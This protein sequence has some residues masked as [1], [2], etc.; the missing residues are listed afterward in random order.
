MHSLSNK[1]TQ[2]ILIGLFLQSM[3]VLMVE[4]C[5]ARIL[6]IVLWHHFAFLIISC[7]LLGYGASGSWLLIFKRPSHP[8]YPSVLFAITIVPLFMLVNR[9]PFEPMLLPVQWFQ[10][11]WLVMLFLL[12]SL[13]FFLGGLSLNILFQTYP[14]NVFKLYAV[15]LTGAALGSVTAIAMMPYWIELEWLAVIACIGG[16]ST[17]FLAPSIQKR[18]ISRTIVIVMLLV[19]WFQA[20]PEIKISPYKNLNLALQQKDSYLINRQWDAASRVDW[21]QSHI[22]RFAPGL[23]LNFRDQLPNQIGLTIDGSLMTAFTS[24]QK[25]DPFYDF[26]P[27]SILHQMAPSPNKIAVI[28]A[29][30]GQVINQA[31]NSSST[32]IDIQTENKIIGKWLNKQYRQSRISLYAEPIRTFL[33][34]S[35]QSYDVIWA[36]L[37][38]ALPVGYSG[39]DVLNEVNLETVEGLKTA[40]SHLNQS[41]WFFFHRYIYLPPRSELRLVASLNEAM[42]ELGWQPAQHLAVFRT[43]S[44][45]VILISKQKWQDEYSKRIQ[46]YCDKRGYTLVYYPGMPMASANLSN[47]LPTPIYA[48][49]VRSLLATPD[50]FLENSIFKLDPVYDDQPFFYYFLKWNHLP[51]IWQLFGYK[52]EALVENGILVPVA[53]VLVG[54]V[55]LL[56]IGFPFFFNKRFSHTFSFSMFYFFFIGLGYM[57]IEIVLFEK[58]MLFLG[59]PVHSLAVILGGLLISSGIGSF[60]GG[61]LIE[62]QDKWFQMALLGLILLYTFGFSPVLYSLIHFNFPVRLFFSL[63]SVAL[64]GILMGIPFPSGIKRI[65]RKQKNKPANSRDKIA[66]AWCLNGVASVIASVGALMLAQIFGFR[67]LFMLGGVVYMTAF[68]LFKRL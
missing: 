6:A 67:T 28:Q 58:L 1:I 12:L 48:S 68:L 18:W 59:D 41:G 54:A 45:M 53:F 44:T 16:S 21:F 14:E 37:E 25:N 10:W 47:R 55:A 22:S 11:I 36:S 9:L 32:Q 66:L 20:L 33:A 61:R 64:L 7:A 65:S 39:T 27:S 2:R 13:P 56:L 15:D 60:L 42:R 30:G 63:G 62:K 8:Y 24:W 29:L 19:V 40:L 38:G 43:I 57:T 26:L 4:I 52:W 46:K 49:A 31:L 23:S 35:N 3:A 34:N 5:L 17:T 51:E 50:K